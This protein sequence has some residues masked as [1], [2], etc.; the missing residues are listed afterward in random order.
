M[1]TFHLFLVVGVSCGRD[2]G[3]PFANPR[4]LRLLLDLLLGLAA[5]A[6]LLVRVGRHVRR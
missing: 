4:H 1:A 3:R 6:G 2:E 5:G